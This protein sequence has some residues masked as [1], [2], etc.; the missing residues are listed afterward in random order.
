MAEMKKSRIESID[1]LRGFSVVLMILHHIFYDLVFLAGAPMWLFDNIFVD[2]LHYVSSGLFLTLSGVSSHFSRSNVKR[3]VRCFLIAMGFTVVTSLP[4]L[5]MPIRFGVL[6]LLGTGMVF[7]GLTEQVWKRVPRAAMPVLCIALLV[8]S[9]LAVEY[10]E[11]SDAV[12][13]F[14]FPLGWTYS[15]FYSADW[16]PIFP[17]IFVFLLGTWMGG[18]V[19]EGK[20]PPKFYTVSVPILPA[21][22]RKALWIYIVH[23]PVLYGIMMLIGLMR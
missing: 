1:A 13:R 9:A 22:G 17:W 12:A 19:K 8:G 14:I 23:Q 2:A 20:L 4:F 7:Y 3:G 18:Y 10:I 6:H 11:V 5:N 15:G 16:F 21:I